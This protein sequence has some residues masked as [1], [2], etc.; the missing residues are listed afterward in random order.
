[1]KS[2][3]VS[4]KNQIVIPSAVRSRLNIAS[5]DRLVIKRLS[6][7]EVAFKK[8]PRYQD[9]IGTLVAQQQDPVQRIRKLRD[10][11]E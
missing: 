9:L 2:I 10:A 8:E 5:G 11:W 7:N 4:S 1:M 3:T 6:D